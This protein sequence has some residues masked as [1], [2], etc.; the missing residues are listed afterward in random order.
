MLQFNKLKDKSGQNALMTNEQNEWIVVQKMMAATQPKVKYVTPVNPLRRWAHKVALSEWF[1]RLIMIV[2]LMN[3][4]C[5]FMS[6]AGQSSTWD[7]ALNGA[8][9]GFTAIFVIEMVLKMM[10]MGFRH[11]FKNGWCQLDVFIVSVSVIGVI[12][13]YATTTNS[14]ILP[15]LRVLRVLRI[16]KL[17]PKAKGL[18]I[19]V[20]VLMWSLPALFNVAT[21]LLLFMFI[22]VS[23]AAH[24]LA[25]Q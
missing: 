6:H 18:K 22:Y 11:Y 14:A 23:D 19:M 7:A 17:I 1:D 3:V 2:I 25:P 24:P 4:V 21:V 16:F 8:N 9:V 12:M 10:A 20:T 13:D 5:M 15:L